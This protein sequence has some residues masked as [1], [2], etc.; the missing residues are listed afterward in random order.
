MKWMQEER[1]R[2]ANVDLFWNIHVLQP[3]AE[4][5]SNPFPNSSGSFLRDRATRASVCAMQVLLRR[6]T[7]SFEHTPSAPFE[8]L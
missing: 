1:E 7:P 5:T 3:S 6:F 4:M 2:G 8:F